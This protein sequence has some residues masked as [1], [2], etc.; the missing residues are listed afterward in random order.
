MFTRAE[1]RY[2][3]GGMI[4]YEAAGSLDSPQTDVKH[5][6]FPHP[7]LAALS[8]RHA[9]GIIENEQSNENINGTLSSLQIKQ[10]PGASR[11][12]Q[13]RK[14]LCALIELC[15]EGIWQRRNHSI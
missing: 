5:S 3:N 11:P 1:K 15:K 9:D 8:N 6:W 4:P 2:G 13:Q 12:V 14:R 10:S 7:M